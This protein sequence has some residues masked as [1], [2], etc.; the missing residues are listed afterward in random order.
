MA[1]LVTIQNSRNKA[2][3]IR[4]TTWPIWRRPWWWLGG[5]VVGQV[6]RLDAKMELTH[7]QFLFPRDPYID[8]SP[9]VENFGCTVV[10]GTNLAE[11][12]GAWRIFTPPLFLPAHYLHVGRSSAGYEGEHGGRWGWGWGTMGKRGSQGEGRGRARARGRGRGGEGG[13]EGEEQWARE[14]VKTL[15]WREQNIVVIG[16]VYFTLGCFKFSSN[17]EFDRNM[18]SGTGARASCPASR[19]V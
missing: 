4:E 16:R 15:S 10:L 5:M 14:G 1:A 9:C 13:G 18:L 7:R 19:S 11:N 6:G 2:G 17:F 8:F 3:D 12:V